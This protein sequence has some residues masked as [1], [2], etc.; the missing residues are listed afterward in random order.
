MADVVSFA[1]RD[2]GSEGKPPRR[3]ADWAGLAGGGLIGVSGVL[4]LSYVLLVY[5]LAPDGAEQLAEL[6]EF[7]LS[8]GVL[9][10]S[11]GLVVAGSWPTAVPAWP[12]SRSRRRVCGGLLGVGM[13]ALCFVAALATLG[14]AIAGLVHLPYLL[15]NLT[16]WL[17]AAAGSGLALV[18][19]GGLASVGRPGRPGRADAL[20][21][22]LL[23]V[24]VGGALVAWVPAWAKYTFTGSMG[25]HSEELINAFAVPGVEI[26]GTVGEM[27]VIVALAA[28]AALWRPARFG[29]VLLT[30]AVLFLANQAIAG[31]S[32]V[33]EVPP[34]S[35]FGMTA[36]FRMRISVAGTPWLWAFCGFMAALIVLYEWLFIRSRP[37]PPQAAAPVTLV[38]SVGSATPGTAGD[39]VSS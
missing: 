6:L 35:Y 15:L 26:A 8:A 30:G 5:R 22:A 9:V 19:K 2:A 21:L 10:V 12:D 1:Y 23:A 33:I 16:C 17:P 37:G 25:P 24:T 36:A 20:P 7:G 38:T 18:R 3:P 4:M 14:D 32:A 31:I 28:A 27:T 39:S 29:T 13:C 34:P 11:T